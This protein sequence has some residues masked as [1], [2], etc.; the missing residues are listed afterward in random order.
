MSLTPSFLTPHF[1]TGCCR[2][3]KCGEYP[4][5]RRGGSYLALTLRQGMM[6]DSCPASR[7]LADTLAALPA[8]Q[9][10]PPSRTSRG[11]EVNLAEQSCAFTVWSIHDKVRH[12]RAGT[13]THCFRLHVHPFSVSTCDVQISSRVSLHR[14]TVFL[15]QRMTDAL[16]EAVRGLRVAEPDLGFKPLL[17]KLRE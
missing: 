14:Q 9:R 17:A 12:T 13:T 6:P 15:R 7:E 11:G 1:Q 10:Q 2:V 3:E 5:L 8:S 4:P 16:L